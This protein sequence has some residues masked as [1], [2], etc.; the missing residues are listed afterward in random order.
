[1]LLG[2]LQKH[3]H[4]REEM[5]HDHPTAPANLAGGQVVEVVAP[6]LALVA[7]DKV[8]VQGVV[9]ERGLFLRCRTTKRMSAEKAVSDVVA[10]AYVCPRPWRAETECLSDPW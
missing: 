6:A 8:H 4:E 2:R 5:S 9:G 7:I 1:M 10:R 3:T